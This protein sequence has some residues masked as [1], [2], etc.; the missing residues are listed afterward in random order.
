MRWKGCILLVIITLCACEKVENVNFVI[1]TRGFSLDNAHPEQD[2]LVSGFTHKIL[3]GVVSFSGGQGNYQFDLRDANLEEFNFALPAGSYKLEL[4]MLPASV[5]GQD[6]A[7]FTSDPGLISIG[8]NTD[9]LNIKVKA[10]CALFLVDD[11]RQ[12]LTQ[13]VHMIKRHSY[14]DGYFTSHPLVKDEFTGL[15]Y[16]YFNPDPKP[17]DP[18]AFLWFYNGR[19]GEADGGL[20][21]CGFQ[22]GYQY[23]IK[24][25][26]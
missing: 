24:V 22:S 16:T 15:Y 10:N 2:S 8:E 19:P 5:Y 7:S 12:Q 9:T 11:S 3:G 13:G 4:R 26:D 1:K 14:S 6:F 21:T 17:S 23:Y 20:S 18:S 25:L